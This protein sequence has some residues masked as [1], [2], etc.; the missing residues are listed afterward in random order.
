VYIGHGR[1]AKG[2]M[3]SYDVY[4]KCKPEKPSRGA[5]EGRDVKQIMGT[6]SRSIGLDSSWMA[7]S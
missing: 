1:P 6:R 4:R 5:Q 3:K 2:D 7:S